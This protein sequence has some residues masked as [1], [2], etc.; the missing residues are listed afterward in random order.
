MDRGVAIRALSVQGVC[1]V[2][3]GDRNVAAVAEFGHGLKREHV[4]VRGTVRGVAGRAAFNTRGRMFE[5]ERTVLVRVASHAR[6]LFESAES[7]PTLTLMGIVA[8][9]ALDDPL[10]EAVSIVELEL[11]K[12]IGVTPG[13]GGGRR[14]GLK[15][16]AVVNRN[17]LLQRPT[18]AVPAVDIVAIGAGHAGPCMLAA[19]I[20]AVL[21]KVALQ[22]AL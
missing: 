19:G 16:R 14:L 21:A 10:L 20:T 3:T 7:H 5:D 18:S 17:L 2:K 22:T 8:R 1:R 11:G 6:F 15:G 4:T 12:D 13:T 9:G